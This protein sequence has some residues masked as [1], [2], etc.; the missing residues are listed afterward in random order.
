MDIEINEYNN[1][2]KQK[3]SVTEKINIIYGRNNSGKSSLLKSLFNGLFDISREQ[4]ISFNLLTTDRINVSTIILKQE[5]KKTYEGFCNTLKNKNLEI[6]E[7]L[8]KLR[9]RFVNDSITKAFIESALTYLFDEDICLTLDNNYSDGVNDIINIYVEVLW[10]ILYDKN[11]DEIDISELLRRETYILIDELEICLHLSVQEKLLHRLVYDFPNAKF[12]I[13][14]HS[15]LLL[16]RYPKILTYEIKDGIL[17]KIYDDL[18]YRDLDLL[19]EGNFG[20]SV[21]PIGAK[22]IVDYFSNIRNHAIDYNESDFNDN[23]NKFC[24]EF[25]NIYNNY[26]G[27]IEY[28]RTVGKKND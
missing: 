13:T 8:K 28:C 9:N 2:V 27:R 14:T 3:I 24:R 22:K 21:L 4:N 15:L 19:A 26:I 7:H 16:S 11:T 18:Y 20:I 1:V 25:P 17:E 12:I 23:V 6:R 10:T 5:D